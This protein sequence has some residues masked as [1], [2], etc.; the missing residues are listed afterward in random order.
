[1]LAGWVDTR[2]R[3]G[4]WLPDDRTGDRRA[5]LSLGDGTVRMECDGNQDAWHAAAVS[6]AS[7]I[8]AWVAANMKQIR[9]EPPR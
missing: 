6:C 1:M 2:N 7:Q 4:E 5:T 8:K 3:E 9:P